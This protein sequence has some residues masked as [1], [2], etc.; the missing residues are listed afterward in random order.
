MHSNISFFAIQGVQTKSN[1]F[2]KGIVFLAT[3]LHSNVI[4]FFD[5]IFR[6]NAI[7]FGSKLG[8]NRRGG[9]VWLATGRQTLCNPQSVQGNRYNML[10]RPITKRQLPR[11]IAQMIKWGPKQQSQMVKF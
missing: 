1:E 4:S 10:G 11:Q 9:A 7:S 2:L 6:H 5:S 8:G 3:G